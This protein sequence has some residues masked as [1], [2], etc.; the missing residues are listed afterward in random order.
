MESALALIESELKN[1]ELQFKKDLESAK[2]WD[3]G[4][5]IE[6]NFINHRDDIYPSS[7]IP[8]SFEGESAQPWTPSP[9]PG[10]AKAGSGAAR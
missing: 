4:N 10:P 7:R 8:A 1:V 6:Y 9:E 2:I 5:F 3:V